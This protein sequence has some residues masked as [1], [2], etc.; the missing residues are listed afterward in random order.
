MKRGRTA[1]KLGLASWGR[2]STDVMATSGTELTTGETGA[3]EWA[4]T[5]ARQVRPEVSPFAC[6]CTACAH[7]ANRM[8][9][10]KTADAHLF[11]W[12]SKFAEVCIIR[13]SSLYAELYNELRNL[14]L[15]D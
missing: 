8:S 10:T 14:Q 1:S 11:H 7:T 6:T 2:T 5:Q 9:V 13:T 15:S 3:P 4:E 12:N